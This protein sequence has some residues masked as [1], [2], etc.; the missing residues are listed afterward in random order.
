MTNAALKDYYEEWSAKTANEVRNGIIELTGTPAVAAGVTAHFNAAVLGANVKDDIVK[1]SVLL[2]IY[3]NKSDAVITGAT[4]A[5]TRAANILEA[6][7]D[8]FSVDP[9]TGAAMFTGDVY[10]DGKKLAVD[11]LVTNPLTQRIDVEAV[12]ADRFIRYSNGQVGETQISDTY[13]ISDF[14]PINGYSQLQIALPCVSVDNPVSGY[15]FYDADKVFIQ[16]SGV[17][18]LGNYDDVGYSTKEVRIAVPTGAFFVRLTMLGTSMNFRALS[19]EYVAKRAVDDTFKKSIDVSALTW[20]NG[21][22]N[23]NGDYYNDPS[24]AAVQR[25]ITSNRIKVPVGTKISFTGEEMKNGSYFVAWVIELDAD[26]HF[27]RRTPFFNSDEHHPVVTKSP[28]VRFSYSHPSNEMLNVS[29]SEGLLFDVDEET[30]ASQKINAIE[31]LDFTGQ[32]LLRSRRITSAGVQNTVLNARQFTDIR[33]TPIVDMPGIKYNSASG[34][35]EKSPFIAGVRQKGIPYSRQDTTGRQVAMNIG[36]SAFAT[37]CMNPN[38]KLYTVDSDRLDLKRVTYFGVVCSKMVQAAWGLPEIFN[39][40]EIE[41][42]P[43]LTKIADPHQWD[44]NDIQ[45]GDGVLNPTVHCTICTDILVDADGVVRA[46]E[47]SEAVTPSCVRRVWAV[48]DFFDHFGSYG[49]YRYDGIDSVKYRKNPYIDI[50]DGFTGATDLPIGIREG[51]FVNIQRVHNPGIMSADIDPGRWVRFHVVHDGQ[52]SSVDIGSEDTTVPLP[53]A[54]TGHYDVY[55]EDA[56]GNF[57][58]AS[59]YYVYTVISENYSKNGNMLSVDY[60]ATGEAKF[61]VFY[62]N[63]HTKHSLVNLDNSGTV[64]TQIPTGMTKCKIGY[65]S[66]YGIFYGNEHDL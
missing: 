15:A 23:V 3:F 32:S 21:F 25:S 28:N 9:E 50:E 17:P 33:W 45:I 31:S 40:E 10:A 54:N 5:I 53:I 60:S 49:L 56:N 14:I 38:S 4:D 59:S 24:I 65:E 37:A 48:D 51:S 66:E 46:I 2:T 20:E 16:D 52:S 35:Y 47:I 61:L 11:G 30:P 63:G 57:G 13:W 44:E 62:D 41:N 55:P 39:S 34:E 58:N 1:L 64:E 12:E 29:I 7:E 43:G 22:Y 6:Y 19:Q 26:Y 8:V 42:L 27:V 36:F 18:S